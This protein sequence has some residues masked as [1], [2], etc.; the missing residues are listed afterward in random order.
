MSMSAGVAF[1]C[2]QRRSSANGRIGRKGGGLNGMTHDALFCAAFQLPWPVAVGP[3]A[4]WWVRA[5]CLVHSF[6]DPP[7]PSWG[8]SWGSSLLPSGSRP[9]CCVVA[10]SHG[11]LNGSDHVRRGRLIGEERL[12]PGEMFGVASNTL[13]GVRMGALSGIDVFAFAKKER[14]KAVRIVGSLWRVYPH[15]RSRALGQP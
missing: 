5:D 9:S 15:W 2:A 7:R 12:S 4:A 14:P 3:E 10:C 1:R 13:R 11:V 8:C 6:R